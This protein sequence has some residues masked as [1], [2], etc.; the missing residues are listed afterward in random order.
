MSIVHKIRSQN[1]AIKSGKFCD[2]INK[3]HFLGSLCCN[4]KLSSTLS[5]NAT[6]KCT[7]L[8]TCIANIWQCRKNT[9]TTN[10]CLTDL[11][12]SINV[13]IDSAF[14]V[15]SLIVCECQVLSK[16]IYNSFPYGQSNRMT[17]DCCFI[18]TYNR[19]HIFNTYLIHQILKLQ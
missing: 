16:L 6:T 5:V 11:S 10:A 8:L 3:L 18:N 1:I 14:N 17:M 19:R 12:P 7:Q 13:T 2:K 15:Q 9:C 4:F